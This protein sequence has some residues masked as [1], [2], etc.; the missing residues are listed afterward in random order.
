[1][2]AP[3]DRVDL[4]RRVPKSRKSGETRSTIFTGLAGGPDEQPCRAPHHVC[5]KAWIMSGEIP[6]GDS[7]VLAFLE[8]IALAFAFSGVEGLAVKPLWQCIAYFGGALIFFMSGIKWPWI[9]EK[10]GASVSANISRVSSD[11]RF[12]I[13]IGFVSGI[14]CCVVI[15]PT[16]RRTVARTGLVTGENRGQTSLA[17]SSSR[18][19][20]IPPSRLTSDVSVRDSSENPISGA[21]VIFVSPN[22]TYTQAGLTDAE[23]SVALPRPAAASVDVYCAHGQFSAFYKAGHD[24]TQPLSIKMAREPGAGSL[25]RSGEGYREL[26]GLDGGFDPRTYPTNYPNA[27]EHYA[28]IENLSING[29][30][31]SLIPLK[32]GENMLVEDNAG[33][34]I[35]LRLI[36]AREKCFLFQYRKH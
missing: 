21:E 35:D 9:K 36:A 22:G 3:F 32:L 18:N 20:E 27:G 2:S 16:V 19:T 12:L 24:P 28:Y 8:M 10:F 34:R 17:Q 6:K 7:A 29:T 4:V 31:S 26:P 11:W 14:L 5:R 25:I 23:G 15:L 30:S 33:H 1:M 13:G